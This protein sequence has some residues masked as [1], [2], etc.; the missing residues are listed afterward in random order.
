[1]PLYCEAECGKTIQDRSGI[2]E[3]PSFPM[4]SPPAE[5]ERC[6][7]RI[8]GTHGERIIL[9]INDI[10][11]FESNGCENGFLEVRDGY[12]IKSPLLGLAE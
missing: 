12:W 6:E 5:G 7:W 8:T 9:K 1:M 4:S 2:I 11:I 3:S 10:D